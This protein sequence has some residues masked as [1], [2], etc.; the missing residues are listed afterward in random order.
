MHGMYCFYTIA[1]SKERRNGEVKGFGT[2]CLNER[3][4]AAGKWRMKGC[5]QIEQEKQVYFLHGGLNAICNRNVFF[6][7]CSGR[8]KRDI[9]Q[10]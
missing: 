9:Y 10:G 5:V 3:N 6:G 1:A 4:E 7:N 2:V 8:R